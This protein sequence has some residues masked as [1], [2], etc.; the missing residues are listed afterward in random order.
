[1]CNPSMTLCSLNYDLHFIDGQTEAQGNLVTSEHEASIKPRLCGFRGLSVN[2]CVY[3]E[4]SKEETW[5][6]LCSWWAPGP[7]H[8][9]V[10]F[11]YS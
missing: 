7:K 2:A 10:C 1:M 4:Y 8:F 11:F 3:C 6:L 5:M 9:S